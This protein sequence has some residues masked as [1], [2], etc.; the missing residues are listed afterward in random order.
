MNKIKNILIPYFIAVL[1]I[2]FASL[3]L[4]RNYLTE[5]ERLAFEKEEL[6]REDAYIE[7]M[8]KIDR[9]LDNHRNLFEEINKGLPSD[10][11][12]PSTIKYLEDLTASAGLSLD[13]I[14]PYSTS[15][16]P[17]RA[18]LKET[19]IDMS[20]SGNSYLGVKNFMRE[21]ESTIKLFNIVSATISPSAGESGATRFSLSVTL[22]TYSYGN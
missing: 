16:A 3:P 1:I 22:K 10:P 14:G 11:N 6:S 17:E 9:D 21:L 20:V 12:L 2:L 18:N 7:G 8:K 13:S 5:K 19:T 15:D 4:F